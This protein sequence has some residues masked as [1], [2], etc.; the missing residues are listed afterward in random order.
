M[1][2]L[3][4]AWVLLFFLITISCTKENTSSNAVSNW[5]I[6]YENDDLD[7]YS[8]KFLNKDTGYAIAGDLATYNAKEILMFTENGGNSWTIDTLP[9]NAS[10]TLLFPIFK[11]N[12]L[13][14][15]SHVYNSR[16]NGKTWKDVSPQFIYGSS[17]DD[18]SIIDSITWIVSQGIDVYRT[19]NAGQT[20]ET[21]YNTLGGLIENFTFSSSNVGYASSGGIV[22]TANSLPYQDSRGY[23]L[24]TTNEGQSWTVLSPEPWKSNKTVMPY[25][26]ALQF[27]SEEVGYISTYG[28]YKLYKT[29]DGGSNWTLIHDNNNTTG[30]QYFISEKLGY[31]SDGDKIFV[32]KNG[33]KS[34]NID[35]FIGTDYESG[36]ILNWTFAKTGQGY[37]V[38]RAHTI[39]KKEDG[40]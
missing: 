15:A 39:I 40:L 30:L 8:V 23:I 19:N 14:I 4:I 13:A 32:T 38:T 26:N 10:N 22:E 11:G 18:L 1:K 36:G 24:K 35:Y 7:F 31:Y 29:L 16:D 21:V 17:I 37:A 33:G 25:L 6:I 12:L 9:P 34:W 5:Q 27:I 2:I 20:W 28:D 3:K